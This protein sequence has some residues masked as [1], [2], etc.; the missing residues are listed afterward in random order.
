MAWTAG[1]RRLTQ[2][3]ME[4]NAVEVWRYFSA[5]GWTLNSVAGMLGNMQAESLV[6]PGAWEGYD[7]YVGGYGLVQWTPYTNY[8]D[9]AGAGWQNNGPKQCDRIMFEFNGGY[10]QWIPTGRYPL[11]FKQFSESTQTPEYLAAAFLYNYERAEVEVLPA[12]Q[13]NARY[14]YNYLGGVSPTPTRSKGMPV[15]MMCR[16]NY[17][18]RRIY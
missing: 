12:R 10:V 1:N 4:G 6:N 13:A 15:W 2:S 3:E 16:P 11:T 8:A 9:W 5:R 14:W 7:P 17:K 18:R